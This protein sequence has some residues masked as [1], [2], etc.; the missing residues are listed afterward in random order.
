MEATSA[1]AAQDS[2]HASVIISRLIIFS[3]GHPSASSI[4]VSMESSTVEVDGLYASYP[5]DPEKE[6]RI[7]ELQTPDPSE[8][9]SANHSVLKGTF[10]IAK[11]SDKP[12]YEALSYVWGQGEFDDVLQLTGGDEVPITSHLGAALRQLRHVKPDEGPRRLWVDA[13]CIN[14]QNETEKGYQVALMGTIYSNT[15]GVLAW[16]GEASDE[17]T[18][19]IT[20]LNILASTA[21]EY[22]LDREAA[23]QSMSYVM[24][25]ILDDDEFEKLGDICKSTPYR[26][27]D[28][29]VDGFFKQEWFKRLWI[30]QEVALPPSVRLIN[31]THAIGCVDL[32]IAMVALIR[33]N[34]RHRILYY[35]KEED[36]RFATALELMVIREQ[37]RAEKRAQA[38]GGGDLAYNP[39][40]LFYLVVENASKECTVPKDRLYALL[41]VQAAQDAI[42]FSITVDYS[43]SDAEVFQDFAVQHLKTGDLRLLHYAGNASNTC[44][45]DKLPTWVADWTCNRE[46][47]VARIGNREAGGPIMGDVTFHAECPERIQVKGRHIHTIKEEISNPGGSAKL[48][49]RDSLQTSPLSAYKWEKKYKILCKD[50]AIEHSSSTFAQTMMMDEVEYI[51]IVNASYQDHDEDS[52]ISASWNEYSSRAKE[53]EASWSSRPSQLQSEEGNGTDELSIAGTGPPVKQVSEHELLDSLAFT[54]A[55]KVLGQFRSLFVADKFNLIFGPMHA[56]PGDVIVA[57]EGDKKPFILRRVPTSASGLVPQPNQ[58]STQVFE[59]DD[60]WELIGDCYVSDIP[61]GAPS[62]TEHEVGSRMFCLV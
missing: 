24:K 52:I 29:E 8:T 13:V 47:R 46:R 18:S 11:L 3:Y 30:V 48:D 62:S 9:G 56:R 25:R 14:Q 20:L 4:I 17:T 7:I 34:F 10:I 43:A 39:N 53:L 40:N 1:S 35:V 21:V 22:G 59:D 23:I 27:I 36:K 55:A 44:R 16:L 51:R 12:R 2:G 60:T 28:R 37:V 19:A 54:M 41:G 58:E 6:I 61:K 45:S 42:D 32:Y 5:I 31:G 50:S 49:M 38:G 26:D 57:F 33:H 15:E